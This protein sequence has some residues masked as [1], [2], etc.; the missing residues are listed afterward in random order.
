V[1]DGSD[2]L[3]W[4]DPWVDGIPL[5][6]RFGRLFVLAET[7]RCT[8]AEMSLLGWRVDGEAGTEPEK[9]VKGGENL[10]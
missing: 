10:T 6:E 9:M 2:N 4:T 5:C 3:F 8:V 7:K 1:G